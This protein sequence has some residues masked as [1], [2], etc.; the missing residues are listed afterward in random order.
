L[1]KLYSK[2]EKAFDMIALDTN[3]LVR[4][5]VQDDPVQ[6]KQ[7][8]QIL[9]NKSDVKMT[10]FIS[11]VVITE[12]VWVLESCYNFSRPNIHQFLSQL[13]AQERFIFSG[14]T[15]IHSAIH[16][17]GESNLD[18][19][20]LLILYQARSS[21]ARKLISFDIK[22]KKFDPGYISIPGTTS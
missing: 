7:V 6:C 21:G 1:K 19:A 9:D 13:S 12:I 16:F 14:D 2:E 5:A 15:A 3:I 8:N 22:L 18:F 17:Y 11:D 20:D 4:Y 10:F